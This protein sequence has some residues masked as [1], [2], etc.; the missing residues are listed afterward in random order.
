MA[1]QPS[2]NTLARRLKQARLALGIPQ[3]RLGVMIGLDEGCASARISRYESGVH[4]PPLPTVQLLAKIL[5]VPTAFLFCEDDLLAEA[6]IK[7]S[8][9]SKT[10]LASFVA[11]IN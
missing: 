8:K 3:D 2:P 6:I 1:I 10:E 5:C 11:E 7:L 4:H 9:L